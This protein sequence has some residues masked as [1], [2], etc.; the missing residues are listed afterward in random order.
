MKNSILL[1]LILVNL[2]SCKYS[3]FEISPPTEIDFPKAE[4]YDL[5]QEEFLISQLNIF[6][7]L[8]QGIEA[9]KINGKPILL[10]FTGYALI[11][12]R[13]IESDLLL[14][15]KTIF[16][17]MKND[18][19]NVWLYIDDKETGK[20]WSDYQKL[21]FKSNQQPYFVIL[22]SKGNPISKGMWY[23]DEKIDLE[24]ELLNHK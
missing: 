13:K 19:T 21:H 6:T 22:D 12:G 17:T 1:I 3:P 23:Y 24:I 14:E 18:Y 7:D 8:N 5:K 4:T 2:S 16:Q 15:N 9:S 20:K 10:Y 11:N